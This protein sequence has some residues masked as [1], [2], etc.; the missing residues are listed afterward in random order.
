MKKKLAGLLAAVMV[1]TMGTTVFAAQSAELGAEESKVVEKA[2]GSV[3][4]KATA[5]TPDGTSVTVTVTAVESKTI[6]EA[7]TTQAAEA[8]K[9]GTVLGIVDVTAEIPEGAQSVDVTLTVDGIKKGDSIVVLHQKADGTWETLASKVEKDGEVIAT[10]TS[11]SPVVVVKAAATETSQTEGL[12]SPKDGD[13]VSVLPVLA[14]LFAVGIVVFGRKV[15]F[16]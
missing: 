9:G 6:V 13:P 3:S 8:V 2:M 12:T 7:A 16:N 14:I 11:F 10:F 4:T 5:V 15:K 1:L